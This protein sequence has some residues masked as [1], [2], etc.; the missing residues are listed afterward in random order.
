MA[1]MLTS[2][3]HSPG[4]RRRTV[5]GDLAATSRKSSWW[6]RQLPASVGANTRSRVSPEQFVDFDLSKSTTEDSSA[7]SK[8]LPI[9]AALDDRKRVLPGSQ[10]REKGL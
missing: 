2:A 6:K 1:D 4:S 8:R 5:G 3:S 10:S 9:R 7:R